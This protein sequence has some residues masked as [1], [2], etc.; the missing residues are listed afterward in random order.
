MALLNAIFQ[1]ED[2]CGECY[3]G[4][5]QYSRWVIIGYLK[6]V[7]L[8]LKD[9]AIGSYNWEVK[10]WLRFNQYYQAE[11]VPDACEQ[12]NSTAEYVKGTIYEL[13]SNIY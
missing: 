9:G 12:Q 8:L 3:G 6:G 11:T 1:G 5:L 10:Y 13:D 7:I 4:Q 2:E